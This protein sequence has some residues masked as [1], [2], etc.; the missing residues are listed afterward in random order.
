MTTRPNGPMAMPMSALACGTTLGAARPLAPE[1]NMASTIRIAA[2]V[3]RMARRG[4]WAVADRLLGRRRDCKRP[5]PTIGRASARSPTR[6]VQESGPSTLVTQAPSRIGT[7]RCGLPR[8]WGCSP[9]EWRS[10]GYARSRRAGPPLRPGHPVRTPCAGSPKNVDHA[11][12]LSVVVPAGDHARVRR[13]VAGP[14]AL[15]AQGLLAEHPRGR[16]AAARSSGRI[17]R[18]FSIGVMGGLSVLASLQRPDEPADTG[19]SGHD[20]R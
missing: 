3:G 4:K 20:P 8:R 1:P 11:V 6:P 7:P 5:K 2:M 9:G 19:L 13:G 18:T 15:A 16:A 14:E 10:G 17:L 12:V